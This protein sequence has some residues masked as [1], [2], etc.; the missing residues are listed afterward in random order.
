MNPTDQNVR[1]LLDE[2][3]VK[4]GFCLPPSECAR[5]RGNPP[6][7]IDVFIESIFVAE[8]LKSEDSKQLKRQI[9]DIVS[10]HFMHWEETEITES[11]PRG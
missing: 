7:E 8:G 3:C 4:L 10:R 1:A 6:T 11:N 5:L 9:R 2:L